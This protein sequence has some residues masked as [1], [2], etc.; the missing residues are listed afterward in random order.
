M[1][2]PRPHDQRIRTVIALSAG[3]TLLVAFALAWLGWK[4]ISQERAL[5]RQRQRERLEQAA[6]AVAARVQRTFTDVALRQGYPREPVANADPDAPET[7]HV[8]FDRTT[9]HA[10]P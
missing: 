3:L 5:D 2:A 9:V 7:V 4:V 6:D 1:S 8:R 10:D